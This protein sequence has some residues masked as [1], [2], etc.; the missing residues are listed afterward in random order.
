MAGSDNE[1]YWIARHED[2]RHK[3]AAVGDISS[4][5]GRNL[6]LYAQKKRRVADLL[7][8]MSSLDLA[9]KTV[10][11]AGCGVGMISELFYILGARVSGVDA[12]P[13]A[14]EEAELRCPGGDFQAGSL[15][16][17]S[18][19]QSF[20]MVFCLDVLYHVIDDQNWKQ[21][22]SQLTGHARPGGRIVI[23]DQHKA[24]PFSPADHV[25]FR[26]QG[27][28]DEAMFDRG[29]RAIALPDHPHFLV[30]ERSS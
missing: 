14:A 19:S 17:F 16:D 13:V 23:I 30:Y 6:E 27:M 15:L 2:Y 3:L 1:A 25:R 22:L 21:V 24:E 12:S 9:G 11:D 29:A 7:K 4:S 26:T 20:D 28:Y 10:L 8:T 5:E 18:F